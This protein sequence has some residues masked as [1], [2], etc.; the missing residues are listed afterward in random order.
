MVVNFAPQELILQ[1]N[2]VGYMLA[3]RMFFCLG[4]SFQRLE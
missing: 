3:S 1:H 4:S 2:A